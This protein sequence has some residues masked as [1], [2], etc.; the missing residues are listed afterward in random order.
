MA[1]AALLAAAWHAW[2]AALKLK[3]PLAA[4]LA[5][6][7][8][9]AA[10][11]A[12]VVPMAARRVLWAALATALLAMAWRMLVAA[13][14]SK[15]LLAVLLAMARRARVMA[16]CSPVAALLGACRERSPRLLLRL[17]RRCVRDTRVAYTM[18]TRC[19]MLQNQSQSL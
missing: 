13:L 17:G 1:M 8:R 10:P 5:W 6:D 14:A 12:P 7:L 4:L 16:W 18:P 19:L 15:L 11:A 3:L 9:V 2:M